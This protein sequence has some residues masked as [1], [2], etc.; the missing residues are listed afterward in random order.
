M[1]P[2]QG[3]SVETGRRAI[4]DPARRAVSSRRRA[5]ERLRVAVGDGRKGPVLITGEAGAGKTWL[6]ERLAERLPAGWRALTIEL[7]SALDSLEFLRLVA[8]SLGL[9]MTDKVGT[10]RLRIRAALEDDSADDR[11]WLLIIDEAHLG[12]PSAWEEL[13]ILAGSLGRPGGFAAMSILGRTELAREMATRRMDA[14]ANRLGLHIHL[15]PMDLDEARELL[16][17]HNYKNTSSES[18]LEELHRDTLGNP[19]RLLRLAESRAWATRPGLET[20]KAE[21]ETRHPER[22]M[23]SPRKE[24][25]AE[26]V[27][28]PNGSVQPHDA[29]SNARGPSLIP[30]KPPI[31]F[32]DGLVEV[33]WDGDLESE[34]TQIDPVPADQ[35][36]SAAAEPGRPDDEP[37]EDRYAAL[38]AWTEWTR[39]RE[40]PQVADGRSGMPEVESDSVAGS[41]D[42]SLDEPT[43]EAD[44]SSVATPATIR[45]ENPHDFAPYSQ[46]FTRL[47]QSRQG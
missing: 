29:G 30:S 37:V 24:R 9:P 42:D 13:Q 28:P 21:N 36:D 6:V 10:A 20:S 47:R 1:Q 8:D 23:T 39:N 25:P 26:P 5:L 16:G 18:A 14:W 15:M 3:L 7:T 34:P 4:N 27:A 33:G 22:S 44:P 46:L 19:R 41:D 45:A 11:N 2:D 17:F 12:S 35:D 40:R 38:Q 32:E 31:R 43:D